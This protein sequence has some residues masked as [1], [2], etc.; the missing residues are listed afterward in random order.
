[1]LKLDIKVHKGILF[2][3]LIGDLDYESFGPLSDE[4]NY[5]LYSQGCQ[6]FV[7]DFYDSSYSDNNILSEFQNK[8]VEIYLNCGKVA[9]CGL[10]KH[11][12]KILGKRNEI[13]FIN[14]EVEA[15]RH[16]NL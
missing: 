1:M 4:I 12:E 9:L 5:L 13:F 6:N 15:F 7:F 14:N 3:K 8:L 10:K 2:V 11:T 16:F